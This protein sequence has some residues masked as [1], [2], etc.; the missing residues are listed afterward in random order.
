MVQGPATQNS[1]IFAYG[2]EGI[3][4]ALNSITFSNNV[5]DNSGISGALAIYD[6]P[7]APVPVKGSGNTFA[8]S[9]T[10]VDP[11]SADQLTGSGG[12]TFSP[13]GT[14]STA[15]SGAALV[16]A[17]GTWTWGATAS[18]TSS[19]G[20]YF[21]KLNGASADGGYAADM[22]VDHDAQMYVL[23]SDMNK[24]YIW[25]NGGWAISAGP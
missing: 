9:L 17:A 4:Y 5:M 23:N 12:S 18:G 21:I 8:S 3:I 14:I 20:Q 1:T 25:S 7:S 6:N 24:W 13:D 16:T 15:P 19:A 22:E 10:E 11:A 2:E